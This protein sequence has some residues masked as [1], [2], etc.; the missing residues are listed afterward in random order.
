MIKQILNILKNKLYHVK[1]IKH[2]I[3]YI[4]LY[5]YSNYINQIMF[6]YMY[7]YIYIYSCFIFLQLYI[8]IYYYI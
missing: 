2:I 6:V 4:L 7:I 3:F 5:I 1:L 8:Y